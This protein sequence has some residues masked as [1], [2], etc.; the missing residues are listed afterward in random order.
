MSDAAS[1]GLATISSTVTGTSTSGA[2][3]GSVNKAESYIIPDFFVFNNGGNV[4]NQFLNTN[5]RNNLTHPTLY[6][7]FNPF[8]TQPQEG[9][10]WAK[11]PAFGKALNRFAYTTPRMLR[12]GFGVRF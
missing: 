5:V 6:S 9:V 12:I 7:P 3:F 1:T 4:Q 10:H 11:D 8:T 2:A